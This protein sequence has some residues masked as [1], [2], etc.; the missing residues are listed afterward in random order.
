ERKEIDQVG[1]KG[2]LGGKGLELAWLNPI[3]AFFLHIQG[4]G[5]VEFGKKRIRVGYAA[6]NG[7][8]YIPIGKTLTD[9]IPLEQMS[10]QR[11]PRYLATLPPEKQQEIFNRNPSYVFF[12]KLKEESLTY[13]GAAVTPGRTIASDPLFFPKGLLAFLEIEEPHF[14][15]PE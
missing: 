5:V 12:Q 8:P 15:D 10:L 13:S 14:P 11:L 3:D 7:S 2:P 4:S 9:V 6:Q 1:G